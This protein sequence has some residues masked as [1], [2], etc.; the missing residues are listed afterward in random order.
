VAIGQDDASKPET[1]E[2]EKE[3]RARRLFPRI[4]SEKPLGIALAEGS[5]EKSGK[6]SGSKEQTGQP[7][8][9][10]RGAYSNPSP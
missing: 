10:S 1:L 3:N 4:L 6:I 7:G 9:L 2:P 8:S 5:A